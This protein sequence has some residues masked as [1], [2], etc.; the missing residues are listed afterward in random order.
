MIETSSICRVPL[1]EFFS[2]HLMTEADTVPETSY[3]LNIS[4]VINNIQH[5]IYIS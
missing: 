3:I 5:T 1:S 2:L 4:K